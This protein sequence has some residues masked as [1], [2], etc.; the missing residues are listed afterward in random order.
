MKKWVKK[1][2]GKKWEN[3]NWLNLRKNRFKEMNKD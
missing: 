1:K 3:Q 2:K